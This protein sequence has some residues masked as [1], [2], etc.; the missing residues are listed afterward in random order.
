M[1]EYKKEQGGSLALAKL[2]S[3]PDAC[4][5]PMGG[6]EFQF[7]CEWESHCVWA[8]KW[9]REWKYKRDF[10]ASTW[11]RTPIMRNRTEQT[12]QHCDILSPIIL[13]DL[14]AVA[15]FAVVAAGFLLLLLLVCFSRRRFLLPRILSL[16]TF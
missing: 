16:I 4:E 14:I 13:S 1:H 11:S 3:D 9:E 6:K 15:P 2:S 10:V 12:H 7:V 5:A 8:S